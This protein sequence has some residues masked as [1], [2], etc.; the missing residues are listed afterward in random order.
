MNHYKARQR[1]ENKLDPKPFD[2][3]FIDFRYNNQHVSTEMV[4][5]T[6]EEAN[7]IAEILNKEKSFADVGKRWD[8]E[9]QAYTTAE[10]YE[11]MKQIN[12][13]PVVEL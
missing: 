7:A 8:I 1:T 11:L 9:G 4:F 10:W 12:E 13:L 6:L 3:V 5:S 2:V